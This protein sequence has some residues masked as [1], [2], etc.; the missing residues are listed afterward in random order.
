MKHRI[1]CEEEY[2]YELDE[3][4]RG[5]IEIELSDEELERY[6]R[7]MSE[8]RDMQNLMWERSEKARGHI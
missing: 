7:V 6:K 4:G 8:F 5:R 1:V 3:F 2:I